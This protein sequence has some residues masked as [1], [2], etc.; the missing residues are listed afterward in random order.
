MNTLRNNKLIYELR[1]KNLLKYSFFS[2]RLVSN[3][4]L[5]I[6]IYI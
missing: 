4:I 1:K 3:K 6:Y 2:F 5:L